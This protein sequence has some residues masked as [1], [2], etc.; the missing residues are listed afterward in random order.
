M[1]VIGRSHGKRRIALC[2]VQSHEHVTENSSKKSE[3]IR[4]QEIVL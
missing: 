4:S 3:T 1:F 2:E